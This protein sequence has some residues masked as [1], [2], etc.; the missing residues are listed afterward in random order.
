M[1]FHRIH[2]RHFAQIL[3]WIVFFL[4]YL[5]ILLLMIFSFLTNDFEFTFQWYNK[6]FYNRQ[7]LDSFYVSLIVGFWSTLGAT[8][9][10]TSGALALFHYQGRTTALTPP[11]I[12]TTG[13]KLVEALS[14]V[15]LVMP[16]IVLGLS[17]LV[18]FVTLRLDL[19]VLTITISHIT[20]CVSYV[21]ISVKARLQDFDHSLEE[22]AHDLGAT[23]WIVFWKI[24]F[25]LIWPGIFSGALMAFTLS[26]DDFLVT[27]FTSGVGS[28][29]LP[30]RIYAMLKFGMSPEINALSTLMIFATLIL[31]ALF[32]KIGN[33]EI[34]KK[35]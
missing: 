2:Y 19:G 12:S 25:P 34:R 28:D 24:T 11:N 15:P 10:G 27:F 3:T 29:T 20:L 17:L 6:I 4:L 31:V 16:E 30:L 23:S 33:L 35:S 7:I 22:A 21:V 9:L 8:V 18:W 5:P 26:F 13:K 32:L 1:N 14:Y